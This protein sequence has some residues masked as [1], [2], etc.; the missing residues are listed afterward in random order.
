[1]AKLKLVN[2]V[3]AAGQQRILNVRSDTPDIRD[4]YYEPALVQLASHVDHS[5]GRVLD[6]GTEGA[7]TGFAL[8]AVINLLNMKRG[9]SFQA[10]P[11]ML[12]EMAQKHDQWP[13]EDYEG[14]SCRGAIR[15]WRNMG[16]CSEDDW[17]YTVGEAGE[18]TIE[19]AMAARK[20]PLGAYYRLRPTIIDYHAALNEVDAIYV[21]ARVHA[22]WFDP[23]QDSGHRLAIIQPNPEP[24]G[25]HAFAIV[26]YNSIGFIVQNSW[27]KSWGMGGFAIWRYVDW[28]ANISDG[29]VF[30]LGIPTPTIFGLDARTTTPAE[31]AEFFKRGPKR[32]EIA[33]HFAHFDDGNYAAHGDYWTT[34]SDIQQTADRIRDNADWYKHVLVYVHGGL[35]SPKASARRIAALKNGFTRNGIYPF[36]IMYDTGL[37]EELKD[38]VVRAFRGAASRAE[39]FIDWVKDQI[40]ERTDTLIEDAVRKPVTPLWE[41]M[42]RDARLPF[43]VD[44]GNEMPDGL[45]AI[46]IIAETLQGTGTKIHLVGHSTGGVLIGH[47]LEALDTLQINDL[48]TTCTLFAPACTVDFFHEHYAPRLKANHQG[49]RL[50]VLD[51]Y[52]LTDKLELDDNVVKAYRKSLLYLV[53]NALERRKGKPLLGMQRFSKHLEGTSGLNL[54]YSNGR[55]N[56]TRSE[57]H[58]GFDN[59]TYTM[60]SLLER[61]LNGE[62][63]K[64]FNDQEM[65]GY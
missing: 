20:N 61:V 34:A 14:S 40:V 9:Q 8:A 63:E 6:Q 28:Q 54:I 52:N 25:G 5:G 15:G 7:C 23:E 24:V 22:G 39:G 49:T 12:Y 3:K 43:K 60:N 62:A 51:I 10:S 45:D 42:K 26:G 32:Q 47:L 55:G 33:G 30:R 16:V 37:A 50:P 58:G 31:E 11:R 44:A 41:E 53:S 17:E 29:W 64:P 35:N 18:L 36:H 59:D 2:V 48:I 19:R 13:G 57:S 1:M 46:N 56:V 65:E 38:V 4:R 21:S 27:G